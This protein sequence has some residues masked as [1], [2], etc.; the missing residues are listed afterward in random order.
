MRLDCDLDRML[1]TH[2]AF[3]SSGRPRYN[4]RV[5]VVDDYDDSAETLG[6]VVEDFGCV[7]RTAHN[8]EEAI[9]TAASFEP[10]VVFLDLAM[11]KSDG[12]ATVAQLRHQSCSAT[13][14]AYSGLIEPD[15]AQRCMGAGF[16]YFLR[17]P[18]SVDDFQVILRTVF[19]GLS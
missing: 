5:L 14:V 4:L 2:D 9:A 6:W 18:A 15:I 17:K 19:H 1:S 16:H 8:A 12:F 10:H 3:I 7:V 11:P 13:L